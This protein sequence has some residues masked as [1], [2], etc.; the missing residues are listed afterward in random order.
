MLS[1]LEVKVNFYEYLIENNLA[2]L[3]NLTSPLKIGAGK[4]LLFLK[5]K[6]N[7]KTA[8]YFAI[9]TT[10]NI[11]L[12]VVFFTIFSLWSYIYK[13]Y[14]FPTNLFIFVFFALCFVHSK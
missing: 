7:M 14:K 5:E 11:H 13:S 12:A 3:I 10:L 1:N 6:F 8:D 9:F 2:N 4:K